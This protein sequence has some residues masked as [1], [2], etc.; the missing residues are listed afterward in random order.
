VFQKGC[1]NFAQV[2]FSAEFRIRKFPDASTAKSEFLKELKN[3]WE[4]F[5]CELR[6]PSE[7]GPALASVDP[8]WKHFCGAPFSGVCRHF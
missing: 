6:E 5:E 4:K 3:D 7:P 1:F 2:K 8:D